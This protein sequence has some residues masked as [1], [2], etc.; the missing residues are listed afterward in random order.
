MTDPNL[1]R[2]RQMLGLK[3]SADRDDLKRRYAE[4]SAR[5][6]AQLRS[7]DKASAQR[8]R[9]NLRKLQQAFTALAAALPEP[10]TE[11]AQPTAGGTTLSIEHYSGRVGFQVLESGLFAL[12]TK[13]VESNL[14]GM[15][16]SRSNAALKAS[17]PAGKL[18]VYSDH[19]RVSCLLGSEEVSLKQIDRIEKVWYLPLSV[20]IRRKPPLEEMRIVIS[21]WGIAGTIKQLVAEHR[22][23]VRIAY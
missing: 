12:E 22:L 4:L 8:G 15:R 9:N 17:W 7:G 10:E 1:D 5:F 18:T 6:E 11:T 13:S 16:T 19:I 2:Y 20:V 21:G 14:F 3:P 23:P